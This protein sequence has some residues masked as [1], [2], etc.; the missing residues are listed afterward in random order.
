MKMKHYEAKV[1]YMHMFN[2]KWTIQIVQSENKTSGFNKVF[3]AAAANPQKEKR[4]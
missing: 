2:L 3:L 1:F 4:K